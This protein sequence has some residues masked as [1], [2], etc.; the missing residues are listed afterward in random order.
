MKTITFIKIIILSVIISTLIMGILI[1]VSTPKTPLHYYCGRGVLLAHDKASNTLTASLHQVYDVPPDIGEVQIWNLLDSLEKQI[2][3]PYI[4]WVSTGK[5]V[6]RRPTY[7]ITING[8]TRNID[9]ETSA[10]S[11]DP[12]TGQP[13]FGG[14]AVIVDS[15]GLVLDWAKEPQKPKPYRLPLAWEPEIFNDPLVDCT[16]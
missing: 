1:Y 9:Y 3:E 7:E 16:P 5:I 15:N 12:N 6:K 2:N 10:L 14:Y 4:A 13:Y 8:K 11:F